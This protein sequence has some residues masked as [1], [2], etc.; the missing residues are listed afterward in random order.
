MSLLGSLHSY[1]E[2]TAFLWEA[3]LFSI[4]AKITS[5]SN[6]FSHII[7]NHL[8]R[9]EPCWARFHP[10]IPIIP[11]RTQTSLLQHFPTEGLLEKTYRSYTTTTKSSPETIKDVTYSSDL[12]Q[13]TSGSV[14]PSRNAPIH[15]LS[16]T[17]GLALQ[18]RL[19]KNKQQ[20][21]KSE[22]I[23]L[24]SRAF[25]EN[26]PPTPTTRI[27]CLS[28][29][30]NKPGRATLW[31]HLFPPT[32]T[33]VLHKEHPVLQS[34][35]PGFYSLPLLTMLLF[36][37]LSSC[38]LLTRVSG[39]SREAAESNDYEYWR[40]SWT[41]LKSSLHH[42]VAVWCDRGQRIQT[43]FCQRCHWWCSDI[44]TSFRWW[45]ER[46]KE[47]ILS[48][49]LAQSMCLNPSL[50]PFSC[51]STSGLSLTFLSRSPSP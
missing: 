27:S 20:D 31:P 38:R 12:Q 9:T 37:G 6:L 14:H 33:P 39:L 51:G 30:M 23:K 1:P 36:P 3:E 2:N 44:Y 35:N 18:P 7:M 17:L 47:M 45:P 26:W 10:R 13:R 4:R 15:Y 21:D 46:V 50:S 42:P 29:A 48:D 32:A 16:V 22:N 24:L 49:S 8:S 25:R 28:R 11:L 43:S 41:E 19:A 5:S 40:L 34:A